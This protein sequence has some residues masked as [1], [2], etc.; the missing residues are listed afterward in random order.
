MIV[1][2]GPCDR[3]RE[4][5]RSN[6]PALT[7]VSDVGY[8]YTRSRLDCAA[9]RRQI[10]L[11]AAKKGFLLIHKMPHKGQR[12]KGQRESRRQRGPARGDRVVG[13]SDCAKAVALRPLPGWLPSI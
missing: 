4:T 1:R 10:A 13:W 8:I 2:E 6:R 9:E 3:P 5:T 7:R 11:R 12:D